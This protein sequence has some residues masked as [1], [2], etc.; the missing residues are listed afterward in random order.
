MD[1]QRREQFLARFQS[2]TPEERGRTML[3]LVSY[4]TVFTVVNYG[5]A[6]SVV[7]SAVRIWRRRDRGWGAAVRSGGCWRTVAGLAVASAVLPVAR[8]AI[9]SS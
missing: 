7:V 2:A 6:A 1:D 8:R 5:L 3:V 4:A 9:V